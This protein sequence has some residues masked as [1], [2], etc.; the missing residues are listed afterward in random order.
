[1]SCTGEPDPAARPLYVTVRCSSST[2][3][4]DSGTT[5]RK[6]YYY[7]VAAVNAIRQGGL[8]NQASATAPRRGGSTFN[9]AR[10][11]SAMVTGS[12][13]DQ[14]RARARVAVPPRAR[15]KDPRCAARPRSAVPRARENRMRGCAAG[16][17]RGARPDAAGHRGSTTARCSG[18]CAAANTVGEQRSDQTNR[19]R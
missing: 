14:E 17:M 4:Y 9:S 10:G 6:I 19:S 2:S 12:K 1:M 11:P 3:T 5:R 15:D 16:D 18:G 7:E 13:T 8:S